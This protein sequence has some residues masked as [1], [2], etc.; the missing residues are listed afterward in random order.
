MYLNYPVQTTCAECG[1]SLS[2]INLHRIGELYYCSADAERLSTTE[3]RLNR[4]KD[5]ELTEHKTMFDSVATDGTSKADVVVNGGFDS[6]TIWTKDADVTISGGVAVWTSALS[7]TALS[8]NG[9]VKIGVSYRIIFTVIN[10]SSGGI[11]VIIGGVN[12]TLRSADGTYTEIMQAGVN[13]DF[14]LTSTGTG[15]FKVDNIETKRI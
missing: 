5:I 12:G 4:L 10:Y 14:N 3:L 9:I 2:G 11:R 6:D 15:T 7:G 8:Q 1:T 13:S